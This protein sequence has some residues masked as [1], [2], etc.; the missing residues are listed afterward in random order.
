MTMERADAPMRDTRSAAR[1]RREQLDR[2]AGRQRHVGRL[3]GAHRYLSDQSRADG[4]DVG[5]PSA[6]TVPAQDLVLKIGER[7]GVD[8]LLGDAGSRSYSRPVAHGHDVRVIAIMW[9]C[10]GHIAYSGACD[11][12]TAR[13]PGLFL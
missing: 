7:P 2:V 12:A 1:E 10:I 13:S 8:L 11:E 9:S 5:E 3:A 4:E 6:V